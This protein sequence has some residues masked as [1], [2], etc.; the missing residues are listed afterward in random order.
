MRVITALGLCA[1]IGV[2]KY[3]V[4]SKTTIMTLP[5]GITSFKV[6]VD[7]A[8][9]SAASL[10]NYLRTNDYQ[11]PDNNKTTAFAHAFGSEFWTWLK[12]NSEHAATFNGYMASRR[13]GKPSWFDI[14]PVEKELLSLERDDAVTLVDIGGNQG[15]DLVK[16]KAKCPN[17]QG[18]LVLQDRP[19]VVAEVKFNDRSISA[20]GHNFFEPQPIKRTYAHMLFYP[21]CLLGSGSNHNMADISSDAQAY[22]FRAIF[23]DWADAE[24]IQILTHTAHAMKP[25]FSKLLISEFVLAD[26]ETALFPASLDLQ[27]MGLH[28]G[29]ERSEGQWRD[30]LGE[31]GLEVV[32][33]WRRVVGGECVIEARLR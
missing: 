25:G 32:R 33:I 12:Q 2:G 7:M 17:L 14:Y 31:A 19:D 1:E 23:H 11:N 9:P 30:L 18:A 4:N 16:L 3:A 10:P 28:A 24:C 5:Q 6:W 13:E 26:T 27:M 8:M 21:Q 20:M 15:H 22:H 29:M